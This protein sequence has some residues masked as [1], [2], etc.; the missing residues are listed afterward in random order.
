MNFSAN[1]YPGTSV[2]RRL[3]TSNNLVTRT[4]LSATVSGMLL[5]RW[6]YSQNIQVFESVWMV[7]SGKTRY[8]KT[9]FQHSLR[10][11][12]Q[13]SWSCCEPTKIIYLWIWEKIGVRRCQ[14]TSYL[15][16]YL[17]CTR[18]L[19]KPKNKSWKHGL[20]NGHLTRW[21][22]TMVTPLALGKYEV[23]T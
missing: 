7:Q 23:S 15:W 10:R 21:I 9:V 14:V 6:S 13:I 11:G 19:W 17:S 1:I 12:S 3:L 20:T 2:S 18:T 8:C 5:T 4:S 16:Q 22:M